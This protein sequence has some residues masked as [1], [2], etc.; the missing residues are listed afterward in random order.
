[1][2]RTEGYA[3]PT[4]PG[5]DTKNVTDETVEY[6]SDGVVVMTRQRCPTI[7]TKK[8][9]GKRCEGG[10]VAGYVTCYNHRQR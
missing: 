1:M 5:W 2:A 6:L 7:N 8:H 3:T 9:A 10:V 4:H